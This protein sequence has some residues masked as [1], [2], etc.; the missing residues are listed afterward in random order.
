M[1]RKAKT[2]WGIFFSSIYIQELG[3][4]HETRNTKHG[5]RNTEHKTQNL[6]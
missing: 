1:P 6:L 4:E 5:T 2:F 3:T